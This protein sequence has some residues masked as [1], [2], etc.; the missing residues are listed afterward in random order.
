MIRFIKKA[1]GFPATKAARVYRDTSRQAWES[2]LPATA[3]LDREIVGTLAKV[4]AGGLMC[5][6]IEGEIKRSHQSVSG[7]LR[8]L[9]ERGLVEATG[10]FD[11][12]ESGRRAMVW[13][14]TPSAMA[15]A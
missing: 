7:N 9:V 11:Q 14:L 2:M 6:A 13:R 1:F 5:Q 12:T 10:M 8:H 15:A 4:G 3:N